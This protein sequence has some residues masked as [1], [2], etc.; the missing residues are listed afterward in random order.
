MARRRD[1][2]RFAVRDLL[3]RDSDAAAISD[4]ASRVTTLD[5][6]VLLSHWSA[7]AALGLSDRSLPR[8]HV[9]TVSP[10][11]FRGRDVLADGAPVEPVDVVLVHG[12]PMTSAARTILDLAPAAGEATVRGLLRE[13]QYRR[14]LTPDSIADAAARAPRHP[15][16]ETVRR[17]DAQ[18]EVRLTG[19]SP[20]AGDLAVFLSI[21]TPL[22]TAVPQY[23][24][25]LSDGSRRVLDFAWPTLRVAVEADGRDAHA[26]PQGQAADARRDAQLLADGWLT[27]RVTRLM[28]A[29]ERPD[30]RR[31]L[32]A[33]ASRRGWTI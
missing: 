8:E 31:R 7:A 12:L 32:I 6:S 14:L 19:D 9:M 13:G 27:V 26:T 17:V 4:A 5:G 18:L 25:R 30:L 28:L 29:H 3:D 16:I 11:R 15:G 20:L 1:D 10:R 23:E 21:E 24:L 22:P 2:R 33:I